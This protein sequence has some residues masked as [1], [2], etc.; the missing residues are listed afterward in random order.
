MLRSRHYL[1][2]LR[3]R[4]LAVCVAVVVMLSLA[5]QWSATRALKHISVEDLEASIRQTAETLNLA[6]APH[7]TAEGLQAMQ[8]YLDELVDGEGS[9]L[10]YLAVLDDQ[11]QPILRTRRTPWPL[12]DNPGPLEAQIGTGVAHVS[13]PIVIYERRI[14]R[15]HYGLSTASYNAALDKVIRRNMLG[16]LI[17]MALLMGLIGLSGMHLNRRIKPL[18]DA[19]TALAGGDLSARVAR[20]DGDCG[21]DGQDELT[22]LSSVFNQMADAVQERMAD[23]E[24]RRAEVIALNE[25]LERRV[26]E[27]TADLQEMVC[28]LESFNRAVSHDLRGPLGGISGLAAMASEALERNNDATLARKALP[29]IARQASTTESMLTSLLAL[30]RVGDAAVACSQVPVQAMVRDIIEQLSLSRPGQTMPTVIVH[31]LPVVRTDPALLRPALL[32]LISN[33]VKF[34][35]KSAQPRVEVGVMPDDGSGFH[36]FFVK[37]NGPGFDEAAASKLFTPFVRLHADQFEG[38]GVGLS[39]VRRAINKL[40]GGVWAKAQLGVGATFYVTLPVA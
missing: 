18:I 40:G 23:S 14:G 13:Q 22:H 24:A 38:H 15:L 37:D 36:T 4:L 21:D 10:I 33:A 28:G 32:N 8:P 16:L 12:P 34:S 6:V 30:A 20:R 39:I 5:M 29:A 25:Q 31:E 35:G 27:R 9:R 3:F 19:S 1:T 17:A 2:S 7:T 11:R 26:H